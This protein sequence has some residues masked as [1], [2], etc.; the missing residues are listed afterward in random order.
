MTQE[1][2]NDAICQGSMMYNPNDYMIV[3]KKHCQAELERSKRMQ[4]ALEGIVR[5]AS[6]PPV[7]KLILK[8]AEQALSDV[9]TIKPQY[10]EWLEID[11]LKQHIFRECFNTVTGTASLFDGIDYLYEHGYL[12]QPTTSLKNGDK[13]TNIMEGVRHLDILDKEYGISRHVKHKHSLAV[14]KAALEGQ[15]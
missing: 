2:Q 10:G 12:S 15:G 9:P 11:E 4:E 8:K 7:D 5:I 6:C 14:I 3:D 13:V 1:K